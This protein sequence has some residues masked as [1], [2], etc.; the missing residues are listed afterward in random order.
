LLGEEEAE[1]MTALSQLKPAE[2]RFDLVT[3]KKPISAIV[4]YAHTP[5]ALQNVLSTLIQ[6]K[7][8]GSNLICIVGC[9][10]DRDTK[11]RPE[12]ARIAVEYADQVI[13][14]SDNPRSENPEAILD[15]MWEG[16]PKEKQEQVLRIADRKEAIRTGVRIASAGDIILVAGKG[17]EK[18]QEIHGQRFPFDDKKVLAEALA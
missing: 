1:T 14:T 4:D 12:M 18:Y 13:L 6:V 10:G 11:K 16:V 9:G 2:G 17:H 3:G 8:A 7:P 15:M 5:D